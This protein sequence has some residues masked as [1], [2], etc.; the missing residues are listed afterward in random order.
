[1]SL[2]VLH[3]SSERTWRGG[4]QQIAYLIDE[5]K[6]LGVKV[7][8]AVK[9]SS[10]FEKYCKRKGI[11]CYSLP[12]RNSLD[13][14]TALQIKKICR[15]LKPDLIHLHSS[16]S[17]GIGVLSAILGNTVPLILSRRVDFV[18]KDTWI[19]RLKYNHP[20]IKRIL[21]VSYKITEI[22]KAYIREP[23]KALTVHS[24]IDLTKFNTSA[25][26]EN[27]LR[28]EFNVKTDTFIIGNTSAL[29]DHKDY[30]TFIDTVYY[31]IQRRIPLKAFIIG[32]GSREEALKAYVAEK[33]LGETIY[34]TGFRKDIV[35]ILPSLDLFLITSNEEGL[36]TS[37]LDAFAAG[38]P[39]VGTAAGGIPE[40]VIHNQTGMLAPI[41]DNRSL[42][43]A[44]EKVLY[45]PGLKDRLINNAKVKVREFS[46]E[47]TAQKT[48][49]VYHE[50]L[51]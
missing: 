29:E 18:P 33:N 39:V 21:C 22:I 25:P 12:F 37:V 17:H 8:I 38:I 24:G 32:K 7:Y 5:L 35:L 6:L 46:K 48:L 27:I 50:I 9:G 40:M 51:R 19:T 14:R 13:F 16:K 20:S 45:E 43:D 44:V 31:L 10:E 42:A 47:E 30:F 4:E 1:M 36:G 49:R 11:P 26:R 34:F 23:A 3:L 28:K 2:T 15:D 41:G